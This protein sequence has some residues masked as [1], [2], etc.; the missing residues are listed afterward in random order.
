MKV[1]ENQVNI[2]GSEENENSEIDENFEKNIDGKM[3]EISDEI[4]NYNSF[5]GKI[6]YKNIIFMRMDAEEIEKYFDKD[7]VDRIYLNF[8]DPWPKKRHSKRR[9]TSSY[10]LTK[11]KN[12]LNPEGILQFK[13]DNNDLFDFSLKEIEKNNWTLLENN[14]NLHENGPAKDNI[15]TEY[16]ERFYNMGKPIN[17]LRAKYIQV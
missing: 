6:P 14:R 17:R 7:E 16:E 4:S 9:L 1:G 11:Y 8:S 12:I 13:T 3:I 15:M 2:A 10:F 5:E